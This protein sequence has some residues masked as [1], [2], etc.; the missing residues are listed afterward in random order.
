MLDYKIIYI[1]LIIGKSTVM[2]HVRIIINYALSK[3]VFVFYVFGSIN[4]SFC[5]N[6]VCR[7][8]YSHLLEFVSLL[9]LGPEQHEKSYK[10]VG[11][12]PAF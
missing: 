7:F 5:I 2:P 9:L 12:F 4:G 11:A 8:T 10:F 3:Q 6:S 1:L